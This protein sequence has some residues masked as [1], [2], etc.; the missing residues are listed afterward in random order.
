M[1]SVVWTIIKLTADSFLTKTELSLFSMNED[2]RYS[3]LGTEGI[4]SEQPCTVPYI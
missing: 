3:S 2:Y 1:F 4:C